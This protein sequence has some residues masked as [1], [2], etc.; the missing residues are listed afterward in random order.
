[1]QFH[2]VIFSFGTQVL[3][4]SVSMYGTCIC[5]FVVHVI[6]LCKVLQSL[7]LIMVTETKK[8]WP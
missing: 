8:T 3:H 4:K 2:P 6:N 7:S 1:M 5:E